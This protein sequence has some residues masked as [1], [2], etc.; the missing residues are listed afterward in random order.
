MT[1]EKFQKTFYEN[2][3]SVVSIQPTASL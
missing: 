2:M 1:S 3:S